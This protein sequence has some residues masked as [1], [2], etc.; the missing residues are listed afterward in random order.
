MSLCSSSFSRWID[1]Q[2]AV[3]PSHPQSRYWAGMR[4]VGD[5]QRGRGSNQREHVGIVVAIDGQHRD[6]DLGFLVVALGKQRTHRA[7]DQP[8]GQD[9][10]FRGTSFALEKAARDFA[11]GVSL[12]LVIHGQRQEVDIWAVLVCRHDGREHDGLAILRQHRAMR[13]LG[14]SAGLQRQFAAGKFYLEFSIHLIHT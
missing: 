2:L 1:D 5:F 12:L 3:D 10:F 11:R 4:D 8:R 9:F 13:L 6:D 14:Q 7:I